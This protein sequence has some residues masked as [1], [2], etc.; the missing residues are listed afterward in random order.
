[1]EASLDDGF[2]IHVRAPCDFFG[3]SPWTC[4]ETFDL[5]KGYKYNLEIHVNEWPRAR[6]C[7]IHR[8][9]TWV[10]KDRI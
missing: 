2:T 9:T 4:E 6:N 7:A 10:E 8:E 3:E 1:M 5:E